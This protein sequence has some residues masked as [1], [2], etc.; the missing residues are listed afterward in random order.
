MKSLVD[1]PLECRARTLSVRT[2]RGRQGEENKH[3][4]AKPFVEFGRRDDR[5]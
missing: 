4:E 3:G 1:Q 5:A 2:T